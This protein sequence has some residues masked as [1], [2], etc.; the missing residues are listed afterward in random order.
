MCVHI[1]SSAGMIF[2]I[3][4]VRPLIR[5]RGSLSGKGPGLSGWEKGLGI[6]G[7]VSAQHFGR[8]ISSVDALFFKTSGE[9]WQPAA[10]AGN[11]KQTCLIIGLLKPFYS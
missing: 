5:G 2:V 1:S 3:V 8:L 7:D 9:A 6:K 11:K 4:S 10:A